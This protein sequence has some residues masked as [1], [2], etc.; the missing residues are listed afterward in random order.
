MIEKST[1]GFLKAIKTNNNKEWFDK[2]KDK[3]LAAKENI[4]NNVALIA[5]EMAKF[6]KGMADINPKKCVFRIYRDVRFSKD[7]RPYKTNLGASLNPG[8]KRDMQGGYYLHIEPSKSFLAG[9]VYMA[10]TQ[11]VNAI[12]QEIDYNQKEFL[13]ITGATDFKKYFKTLDAE[14][15]LKAT[16]KGYDKNHPL[17]DV[18]QN[19]HFIVMHYMKDDFLVHKDFAKK[20]AIIFKAMLPLNLFL[21][22]ALDL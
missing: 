1:I 21:R 16:P 8:G 7:K 10:E 9:G 19:K 22:R 13:K 2:N 4:E 15:K 3:Y 5:K 12:R 11:Q 14:D 18:L 20:T 17:I 6:E